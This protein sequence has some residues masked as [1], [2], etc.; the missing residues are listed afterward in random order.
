MSAK[1]G[2]ADGTDGE[3][4]LAA[5]VV[6]TRGWG[7]KRESRMLNPKRQLKWNWVAQGSVLFD[8]E[9]LDPETQKDTVVLC[10]VHRGGL[11]HRQTHTGFGS[12]LQSNATECSCSAIPRFDWLSLHEFE[13][14]HSPHPP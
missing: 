6:Q 10:T 1:G 13:K 5:K 12:W 4:V 14:R 7:R 9:L 3:K 8:T 2:S 11:V